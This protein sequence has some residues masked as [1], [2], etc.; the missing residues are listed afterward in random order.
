MNVF[1]DLH[2]QGIT[3]VI[4]THELEVAEKT[5]RTIRIQDGMIVNPDN[6]RHKK[7][8]GEGTWCKIPANSPPSPQ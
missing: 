6:A 7:R 4:I 3:I 1:E 2:Q 8:Q 5:R